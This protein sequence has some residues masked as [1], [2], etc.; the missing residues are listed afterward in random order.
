MNK[1]TDITRRDP[2]PAS[3]GFRFAFFALGLLILSIGIA[4]TV[5]A[6]LGIAPVSS[7][8][9]LLSQMLPM[10]FGLLTFLMQVLYVLIQAILYI[11]RLPRSLLLQL[12]VGP[13]FGLFVDFAVWICRFIQPQNLFW[14]LVLLLV[15]CFVTAL[16]IYIQLLPA[17]LINPGEG[18]VRAISEKSGQAF[19]KVK[20]IFDSGLMLIALIISWLYFGRLVGLGVG[21]VVSALTVGWFS[22][23]IDQFSVYI[24]L[25]ERLGLDSFGIVASSSTASEDF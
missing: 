2:K 16:G 24:R 4:F 19:G 18:I 21:T 13:I 12:A 8:P 15:G 20:T 22:K 25:K 1:T 11:R 14:R 6:N 23:R 3:F 7:V 5:Q 10:S 9:F 17:V